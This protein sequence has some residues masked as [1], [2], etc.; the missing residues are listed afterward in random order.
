MY[1]VDERLLRLWIYRSG[2]NSLGIKWNKTVWNTVQEMLIFVFLCLNEHN[3][4]FED[5]GVN[6]FWFTSLNNM[7]FHFNVSH[8]V[9]HDWNNTQSSERVCYITIH[10]CLSCCYMRLF[11]NAI[12]HYKGNY[13]SSVTF[14]Y[15]YKVFQV[16]MWI[17]N[18]YWAKTVMVD[19]SDSLGIGSNSS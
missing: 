14:Q 17:E 5:L 3:P 4:V 2:L 6:L 19:L 18:E 7:W 16:K 15:S 8:A 9:F 11:N 12:L 1:E 10:L 13:D